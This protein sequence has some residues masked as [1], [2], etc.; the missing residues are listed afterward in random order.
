LFGV[1]VTGSSLGER[2]KA[3]LCDPSGDVQEQDDITRPHLF[4][5]EIEAPLG[6]RRGAVW[7]VR[8]SRPTQG[9]LEDYYVRLLGVPPLLSCSADSLLKPAA[10]PE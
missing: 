4:A 7:S 6:G 1:V 8:I 9:V 3:A 10:K 2:V 5:V